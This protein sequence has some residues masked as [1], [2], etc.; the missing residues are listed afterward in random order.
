VSPTR[1]PSEEAIDQTL[2]AAAGPVINAEPP[3]AAVLEWLARLRLLEG[4]PFAYLVPDERL[5]PPES[6]RFFHLDRNWADAAVD[7]ALSVGAGTTRERAHL[8]ARHQTIR[9]AVDAA[10]RNVWAAAAHPDRTYGP[11]AAETV[12]GFLLR[13]RAVSGWPGLHIRADRDGVP[14]RLLRVERLA[15]AVLLVLLDG[16]PT[17]VTIEEPRQ[18]LQF[19]FD[20]AVGGGRAIRTRDPVTGQATD[21]SVAAKFRPGA[22][23]VVDMRQLL[24]DLGAGPAA[25]GPAGLAF[26][27][28][29]YP[30]RQEFSGPPT[31]PPFTP[32]ITL[33]DLSLALRGS[34]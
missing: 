22:P 23:G 21:A 15:P 1:Y 32:T 30:Y 11:A 3:P 10:E 18:G 28:V 29:Q 33:G 5:L 9:A 13:S 4:V 26:Q 16:L 27:L 2:A 14:M 6:I 24:T 34:S 25:A 31:T 8:R 12:T 20:T 17:T 19:G 7:G